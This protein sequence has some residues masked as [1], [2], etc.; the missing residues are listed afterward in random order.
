[1]QTMPEAQMGRAAIDVKSLTV[2]EP[3]LVAI[4]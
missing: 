3:A 1:M 4:G 2:R